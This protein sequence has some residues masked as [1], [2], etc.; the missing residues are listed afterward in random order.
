MTD[1]R[2]ETHVAKPMTPHNLRLALRFEGDNWNAYAATLDTMEG[3]VLL[4]SIKMGCVA[5]N[6]ARKQ[7]FMDL[8]RAVVD[9]Y[10]K[11]VV[12]VKP[13]WGEPTQAPEHERSGRDDDAAPPYDEA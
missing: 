1:K 4:G 7:Q 9:D 10:I 12:G 2:T 13:S 3:A 5:N 8:M 11:D 6:R